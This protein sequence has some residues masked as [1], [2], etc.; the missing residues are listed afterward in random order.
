[1]QCTRIYRPACCTRSSF[2]FRSL[3]LVAI[4]VDAPG[5]GRP[6][7]IVKQKNRSLSVAAQGMLELLESSLRSVGTRHANIPGNHRK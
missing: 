7:F 1:M 6:I 4:P 3:D 2:Q 5:V